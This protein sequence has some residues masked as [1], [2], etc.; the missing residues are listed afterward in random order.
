MEPGLRV[1]GEAPAG[2]P[3]VSLCGLDLKPS[4]SG[5]VLTLYQVLCP[6]PDSTGEGNWADL[7]QHLPVRHPVSPP[8]FFC[9]ASSSSTPT[10]PFLSHPGSLP[11]L[12]PPLAP[13]PWPPL[14]N[15]SLDICIDR[16]DAL[17]LNFPSL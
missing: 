12:T 3:A 1:L 2:P 7:L 10:T 16:R 4:H 5:L 15:H 17:L 9:P 13:N 6:L 8:S 11:W 14:M